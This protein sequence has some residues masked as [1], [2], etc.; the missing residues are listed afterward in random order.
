MGQRETWNIS[1]TTWWTVSWTELVSIVFRCQ[2]IRIVKGLH[3]KQVTDTRNTIYTVIASSYTKLQKNNSSRLHI[4]DELRY[5]CLRKTTY[6]I[7]EVL[8]H[9]VLLRVMVAM[10]LLWSSRWANRSVG[11]SLTKNG[12]LPVSYASPW[13]SLVTSANDSQSTSS[14]M[15]LQIWWWS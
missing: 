2:E 13:S 3:V 15:I 9:K 8:L 12:S 14:S 5:S 7:S 1:P 11:Q 6:D 4:Q 10:I